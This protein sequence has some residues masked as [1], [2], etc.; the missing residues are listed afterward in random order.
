MQ[1]PVFLP[2]L[3]NGHPWFSS[4]GICEQRLTNT[5]RVKYRDPHFHWQLLR[6]SGY[7]KKAGNSLA[8]G[9]SSSLCL[10]ATSPPSCLLPPPGAKSLQMPC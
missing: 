6:Q 5:A 10:E 4:K 2:G 7:P 8:L 3:G 1:I 9:Q